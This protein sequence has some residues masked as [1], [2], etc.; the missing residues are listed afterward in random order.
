M[1]NVF[2]YKDT[3][4]AY[5]WS[6]IDTTQ[7]RENQKLQAMRIIAT[8][9]KS[10]YHLNKLLVTQEWSQP[11]TANI[12]DVDSVR[13]LKDDPIGGFFLYHKQCGDYQKAAIEIAVALGLF[14]YTDFQML[15]VTKLTGEGHVPLAW[16]YMGRY[17]FIDF[18][19][20]MPIFMVVNP[21]SPNGYASVDDLNSNPNLITDDQRYKWVS[22]L[23]GDS[24]NL[25]PW[26][27]SLDGYRDYFATVFSAPIWNAFWHAPYERTGKLTLSPGA[28]FVFDSKFSVPSN[29]YYLSL[30]FPE[31]RSMKIKFDSLA[32]WYQA[33][34]IAH[35]TSR[36]AV[37]G[38]SALTWLSGLLSVTRD[39]A[40]TLLT[41]QG[42]Q[43]MAADWAPPQINYKH[44]VPTLQLIIP[45]TPYDLKVG[46]DSSV[47]CE[48]W[49][50]EI[51]A[52]GT[53]YLDGIPMDSSTF[54]LWADGST[55]NATS[56]GLYRY[57]IHTFSNGL[58]PANIPVVASLAY[59]P[60]IMNP[61]KGLTLNEEGAPDT[62]SINGVLSHDTSAAVII[63]TTVVDT[64][65]I[66][67]VVEITKED[68]MSI[69]PNPATDHVTVV[70]KEGVVEVY[71]LAGRLVTTSIMQGNSI[72]IPT[73]TFNEGVYFIRLND[74]VKKLTVQH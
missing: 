45:S 15:N 53:V 51:K 56:P 14:T 18:D 54:G 33:A 52:E 11:T 25:C 4:C 40:L 12:Y 29:K 5:I 65:V 60:V 48:F 7:T 24:V 59:N 71:D 62:L 10:S 37:L 2:N 27:V 66:S 49:V 68:G 17:T 32:V 20:G 50:T 44:F 26:Y 3:L 67:G 8:L 39:S 61:E 63:D 34:T 55:G 47:S 22:P 9:V 72:T 35:D 57:Q 70:G 23:T 19:P 74:K 69:Y 42:Y 46:R 38:D 16:L 13:S 58:I 36:L 21:A 30:A 1:K 43:F 31:I 64:T 73:A 41:N 6:R 28:S